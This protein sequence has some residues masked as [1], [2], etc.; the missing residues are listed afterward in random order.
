MHLLSW[1]DSWPLMGPFNLPMEVKVMQ[2][3]PSWRRG[4]HVMK[5]TKRVSWTGS[6]HASPRPH[7]PMIQPSPPPELSTPQLTDGH[8]CLRSANSSTLTA[9]VRAHRQKLAISVSTVLMRLPPQMCVAM[10]FAVPSTPFPSSLLSKGLCL[11]LGNRQ[12]S[13]QHSQVIL[14]LAEARSPPQTIQ[15]VG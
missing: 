12:S 4:P 10:T 13:L 9:S 14:A 7:D 1:A 15:A 3:V 2:V 11:S 8:L 5:H 6:K